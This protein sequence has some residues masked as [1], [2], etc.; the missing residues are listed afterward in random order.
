MRRTPFHP[1]PWREGAGACLE[2]GGGAH[3]SSAQSWGRLEH[4][5]RYVSPVGV[6]FSFP[7]HFRERGRKRSSFEMVREFPRL[8]LLCCHGMIYMHHARV[9]DR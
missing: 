3:G 2:T 8:S 1:P 7:G 9:S 4:K 5:R 6:C